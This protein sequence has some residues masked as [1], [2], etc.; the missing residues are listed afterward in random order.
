MARPRGKDREHETVIVGGSPV[1]GNPIAVRHNTPAPKRSGKKEHQ[2]ERID[3]A[4]WAE[5]RL[6]RG[7]RC[8]LCGKTVRQP[9]RPA[10]YGCKPPRKKVTLKPANDVEA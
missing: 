1:G 8:V 9:T 10:V 7:Y 6:P 5:S 4:T 2:W 3:P